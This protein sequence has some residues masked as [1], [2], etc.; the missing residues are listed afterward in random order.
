MTPSLALRLMSSLEKT[1]P[2]EPGRW[3]ERTSGV[4]LRN[5]WHSFTLAARY[6]GY[7]GGRIPCRVEVDSPLSAWIE[8]RRV[9][10]VPS[11]LPCY[12]HRDEGYL[13]TEPGLFPDVL[14][15]VT[16]DGVSWLVPGRWEGFWVRIRGDAS[17]PPGEHPVKVRLSLRPTET[18]PAADPDGWLRAERTYLTT[19]VDALLPPQ[20]VQ[21]TQWFHADGIALAHHVA[22]FSEAFWELLPR[23]VG[24]AV[25]HGATHLLTPLFTP[26]LDTAV[27]G[28][29]PTA[30]LVGVARRADGGYAF[31]FALLDRW[32]RTCFACGTKVFEFSHL[33]S[34]WGL[35]Y[36][37]RIQ[38]DEGNGPIDR[39]GWGADG[40]GQEY[41]DFLEAFLPQLRRHLDAQGLL[42]SCCFHVSDEPSREHVDRYRKAYAHVDRL[43]QGLPILDA[44]SDPEFGS[45]GE[46][47]TPV[48][49]LDHLGPF[50]P[51]AGRKLWTY[52]CC[53]QVAKVSNR[54]LSMPSARNRILG[55]QL[56]LHDI[57]GFLH[58]GYNFYQSK[59]SLRAIDPYAV[60][61]ADGAFPSGDAF[62]VY[63]TKDG[64]TESLR[65][66]VFHEA[67]QDH[68]ALCLLEARVGREAVLDRIRAAF[69][70]GF[71]F[72][73]CPLDPAVLLDFREAVNRAISDTTGAT[74]PSGAGE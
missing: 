35:A 50:L 20:E 65:L 34:Q 6:D 72:E 31:D 2:D 69:G 71:S 19:V 58:W 56:Y 1:F 13:R 33:F 51:R 74:A 17:L 26:P 48:V 42:D 40:L 62:S 14:E 7:N 52:Y 28:F 43:L 3:P 32:I 11:E 38:V 45:M 37:P 21:F 66:V 22:V 73:T 9:R 24:L 18:S 29:R 55:T 10:L 4:L 27:G 61:D 68:R 57:Q 46:H 25:R 49:A 12:D 60:T 53:G 36:A 8:V 39:F 15:S 23:Y 67:L 59:H 70:E 44:V 64:C 54:F 16:D 41:L 63:P 5:E 30:Q 47:H